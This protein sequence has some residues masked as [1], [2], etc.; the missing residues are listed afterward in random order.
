MSLPAVVALEDVYYSVVPWDWPFARDRHAEI[1]AHFAERRRQI[2]ELWNG[3]VLLLREFSIAERQLRGTCF[4]TGFADMIAWRD[5]GFPD[6]SV[7]NS[8]AM[9]ALRASDGAY[10]A[11]VM[12]GHTAN[13]GRVYFPSG[14]PEPGDVREGAVDLEGSVLREVAEETGLTSADFSVETGWTAVFA[15]P[16]LALM[17]VLQLHES[18]EEVASRVRRFLAGER[19]PELADVRVVCN[20]GDFTPDMPPFMIAFLAQ[21]LAK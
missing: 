6:A 9:G 5:W 18:A 19:K 20:K 13:A 2:P 16:R 1:D 10:L 14:T 3:R 11:A 8:F 7:T 21:A 15:A 4:E 17:K 12:S